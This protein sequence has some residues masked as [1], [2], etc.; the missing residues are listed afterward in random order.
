[1]VFRL[2]Y[3]G[4][5]FVEEKVSWYLSYHLHSS[6]FHSAR[7]VAIGKSAN[8]LSKCKGDFYTTVSLQHGIIVLF[9]GK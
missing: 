6:N 5:L 3:F 7:A 2:V 9:W 1:M 4:G 8:G